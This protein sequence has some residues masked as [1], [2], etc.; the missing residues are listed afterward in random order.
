MTPMDLRTPSFAAYPAESRALAVQ[1]LTVLQHLPV[2]VCPSFLQQIRGVP[3]C[4]PVERA[5]L[6]A[7]LD[8][9]AAIPLATLQKD[10]SLLGEIQLP[11]ALL[12]RDWVNEP[13][14]F[15]A[16]MTQ[17]LWSSAQID[18]FRQG[19]LQLFRVLP[20]GMGRG[21]RLVIVVLGQGAAETQQS[22]FGKL[23]RHGIL[24]RQMIE[25]DVPAALLRVLA[26]QAESAPEPYAHWYVDGGKPWLMQT[27]G[28]GITTTSYAALQPMRMRVLQHMQTTLFDSD[29]GVEDMQ[30]RLTALSPQALRANEL[31]PDA[32]LQRFYTELFTQSSGPQVFSTS[33]VQWT[34]RELNR[35]AQPR[36]MLLRYQPRQQHRTLDD[37]VTKVE[38]ETT[39]DPESSLRD[40]EMGAYYTW[41]EMG[42]IAAAKDIVFLV[43][44]EGTERLLLIGPNAPAGTETDTPMHLQEAL[45]MFT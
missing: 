40:A 17:Y 30:H 10:I 16:E 2:A 6:Q 28:N 7:R 20:D 13:A 32:V 44:Q 29:A 22:S 26:A 15:I 39:L 36:T 34:G 41:L 35:R 5:L 33:F 4:F 21:R 45:K 43:W 38:A 37:M 14:A 9:L 42:R 31:T 27:S 24:L 19:T 18:R 23:R 12:K 1:Y 25:P 11:A 3:T 8:A